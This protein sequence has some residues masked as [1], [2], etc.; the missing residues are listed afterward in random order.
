[1]SPLSLALFT[2]N[3]A[4]CHI[5]PAVVCTPLITPRSEAP[6]LDHCSV[7]DLIQPGLMQKTL[8]AACRGNENTART[9]RTNN[10]QGARTSCLMLVQ[11]DSNQ[12]RLDTD[13]IWRD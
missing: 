3:R 6:P 2:L 9:R 1:M 8:P 12:I 5:L 4:E 11:F 13:L 10:N 7:S